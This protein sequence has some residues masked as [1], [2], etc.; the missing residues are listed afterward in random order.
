MRP[1]LK[2][3]AEQLE[4]LERKNWRQMM[5]MQPFCVSL[6]WA[7]FPMFPFLQLVIPINIL[8]DYPLTS[9]SLHFKGK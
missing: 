1:L 3:F 4:K 2:Q 9:F 8:N 6:T 5:E 7:A